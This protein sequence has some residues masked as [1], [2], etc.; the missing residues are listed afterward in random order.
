M[1]LRLLEGARSRGRFVE[2]IDAGLVA[3]IVHLRR[4]L[5]VCPGVAELAEYACALAPVPSGFLHAAKLDEEHGVVAEVDAL[6]VPVAQIAVNREGLLEGALGLTPS[7]GLL[8][9]AGEVSQRDALE[10]DIADLS[11]D[12][13]RLLVASLRL[14]E[15]AAVRV[16]HGPVSQRH[17]LGAAVA[18]LPIDGQR[19]LVVALGLLDPPCSLAQ[20]GP[21]PE[22][23]ALRLPIADLAKC[24]NVVAKVGGIGMGYLN[25]LGFEKRPKPP[26]SDEMLD[27]TRP[28]YEHTIEQFGPDRCMFESNF[29]PDKSSSSYTVLWNHF[30]KLTKHY[31]AHERA[32]MFYDTAMRVY[33][34]PRY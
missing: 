18:D 26:T 30:K 15:P 29:P 10:P 4:R 12:G 7:A 19:L 9:E 21:D 5:L 22:C 31:S 25:G 16:K 3:G 8:V 20:H 23:V 24:E 14:L 28:W 33:R 34:L 1:S 32:Q 27:V 6:G 2:I 13:Q 17:S 11:M